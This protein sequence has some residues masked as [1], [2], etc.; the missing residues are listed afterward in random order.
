MITTSAELA[1]ASNPAFSE[2]PAYVLT[3][4]RRVC[5]AFLL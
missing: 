1:R 2:S 3:Y 4:S 5:E